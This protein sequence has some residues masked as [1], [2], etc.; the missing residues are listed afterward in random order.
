MEKICSITGHRPN[1]FHFKN[2]ENHIDCIRLKYLLIEQIIK[3]YL[4]GNKIFLTGCAIGIDIW[5][6]EIILNLKE[7]HNDIKLYCIIPFENQMERWNDNYKFRYNNL[8]NNCTGKIVLQ[9]NFSKDCY[10]K[11]NKFLV[12]KCTTLVG[13][14]NGIDKHS[15]TYSTLNYALKENKNII[16]IN[17]NSFEVT[18]VR[19]YI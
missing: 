7:K 15:G 16:Y 17:S 3:L 9:K 6:R 12:D 18:E 4:D 8:I 19:T 13:I 11:R 5:L 2:N 1:K 14:Y 10:L